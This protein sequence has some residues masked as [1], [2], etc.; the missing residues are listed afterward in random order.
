MSSQQVA[1]APRPNGLSDESSAEQSNEDSL[2]GFSMR[3]SVTQKSVGE[4]ETTTT[5][6][7]T[8][9]KSPKCEI[10]PPRHCCLTPR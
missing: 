9:F 7:N 6:K 1:P 8:K 3:S 2:F 10:V 4:N 5:P